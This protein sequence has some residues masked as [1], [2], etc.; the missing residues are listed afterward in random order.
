MLF[1]EIINVY[2]QNHTEPLSTNTALLTV[3]VPGSYCN[4]FAGSISQWKFS[5]LTVRYTTLDYSSQLF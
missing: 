3:K 5:T 1:K 4:K 2:T